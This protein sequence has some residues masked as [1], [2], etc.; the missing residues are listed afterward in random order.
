MLIESVV[1]HFVDMETVKLLILGH[2]IGLHIYMLNQC[3]NTAI[4]VATSRNY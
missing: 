1:Q 2:Y 4:I 3:T